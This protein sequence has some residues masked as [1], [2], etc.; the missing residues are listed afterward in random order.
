MLVVGLLLNNIC[1]DIHRICHLFFGHRKIH[2]LVFFLWCQLG[3]FYKIKCGHIFD[4]SVFNFIKACHSGHA[5]MIIKSLRPAIDE[6]HG[7]IIK[8]D[9]EHH[10]IQQEFPGLRYLHFLYLTMYELDEHHLHYALDSTS[11]RSSCVGDISIA[12]GWLCVNWWWL[13]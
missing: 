12:Y 6:L 8:V 3:I 10:G 5:E 2:I 4:F 11:S 7:I 13:H 1:Q 9:Q